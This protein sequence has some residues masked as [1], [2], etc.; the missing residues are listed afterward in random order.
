M[1]KLI[2]KFNCTD[3]VGVFQTVSTILKNYNILREP[4]A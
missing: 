4:I 3:F 2:N 1:S